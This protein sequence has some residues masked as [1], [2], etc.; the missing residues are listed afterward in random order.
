MNMGGDISKLFGPGV[1]IM[2][3]RTD[4]EIETE[5][6][7]RILDMVADQFEKMTAAIDGLKKCI[8]G[9]L[10]K[11]APV[12][13]LREFETMTAAYHA[14]RRILEELTADARRITARRQ[15]T[16]PAFEKWVRGEHHSVP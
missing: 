7:A 6:L 11:R 13:M 9:A 5:R 4:F 8:G 2:T 1:E 10:R 12:G 16:R 3:F 15:E 14:E